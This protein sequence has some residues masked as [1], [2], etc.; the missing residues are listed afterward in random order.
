V[1]PDIRQASEVA[2]RNG[3]TGKRARV[4]VRSAAMLVAAR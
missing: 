3:V 1:A 4:V 2:I